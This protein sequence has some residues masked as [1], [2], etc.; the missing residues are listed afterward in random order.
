M[1]NIGNL[2]NHLQVKNLL[3]VALVQMVAEVQRIS[4]A[5]V[6]DEGHVTFGWGDVGGTAS[7][8]FDNGVDGSGLQF[9]L[10]LIPGLELVT[11][12]GSFALGHFD[13]TFTGVA[14]DAAMIIVTANTLKIAS[15]AIPTPTITETLKGATVINGSGV[16]LQQLDG[17]LA[18]VCDVKNLAGTLP[19]LDLKVQ[20]SDDDGSGDAYADVTDGAFAQI[21]TVASVQKLVLQKSSLKR[22]ARVVKTVG[23]TGVPQYYA[24]AKMYG[25]NKYPA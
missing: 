13:V 5:S 19:T 23:G 12:V 3:P 18:V 15:V 25:V 11:V 16:D 9:V 8:E 7:I 17:Q 22:Y 1:T 6:P 24:S 21:T 14:G 2:G 10:R 4:I 20:H